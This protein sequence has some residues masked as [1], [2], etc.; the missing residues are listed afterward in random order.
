MVKENEGEVAEV[1]HKIQKDFQLMTKEKMREEGHFI[2]KPVKKIR[3]GEEVGEE[4][5]MFQKIGY[6]DIIRYVKTSSNM[7]LPNSKDSPEYSIIPNLN[8][9]S[10]Y[11]KQ[12]AAGAIL[13]D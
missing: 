2:Y 8:I 12:R 6:K 11:E 5:S 13:F 7:H 1:F 3:S 4:S 9:M 10:I